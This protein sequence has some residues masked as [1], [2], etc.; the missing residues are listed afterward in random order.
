MSLKG[1]QRQCAMRT[2]VEAADGELRI[3]AV[4]NIHMRIWLRLPLAALIPVRAPARISVPAPMPGPM[5]PAA[6][7]GH[8]TMPQWD[9]IT[10][11]P[12]M[13]DC[14]NSSTYPVRLTDT[15]G[16]PSPLPL[17]TAFLRRR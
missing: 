12:P 8:T 14:F 15:R 3:S 11:L 16:S 13:A 4:R 6:R 10:A 2:L 17:A 9:S 1:G 5:R 7:T